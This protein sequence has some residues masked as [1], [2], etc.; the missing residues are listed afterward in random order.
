MKGGESRVLARRLLPYLGRYAWPHF[1]VALACMAIYSAT[2]GVV[3]YLVRSL[4]DD[5]L[6]A[7]DA[8]TLALLP[9]L[10]VAV[11][12]VRAAAGFGQ[13]YLGEYVGQHV[14]RDLR[15]DLDDKIQHLPVGYFDRVASGSVLSRVTT[16][17]LL[18]RQALTEGAAAVLR[19]AATVVIL[20]A[21]TFYLDFT[22]AV[23]T[24]VVF[25]AVVLPLQRLSRKM[26]RLSHRGLDSLGDLSALLQ[27]TL[28]GN[29]VV[30]AFG[31]QGYEK[32]R[33]AAENERLL[34]INMRAARIKAFTAPMTEM[35]AALAVAGVLAYG[36]TSVISGGR[37]PGGF[38]AF[39][40]ALVLLYEPFKKIVRTNNVVQTGLGAA[41][42]IFDILDAPAEGSAGEGGLDMKPFTREIRFENVGF[43]YD[44]R[45][46]LAGVDLTIRRGE[47]VALVG[48]SG[49]GKTTLA[50][51]VP[52]FY[53]V[54]SGR[55]T[56]DGIDVRD[57]SL[58][59]LRSQIAVVT[60]FTFLFND[61]V[62]NN[63][64]YGRADT[65]RSDI[66]AAAD[67]ANASAF[68]ERLPQGYDTV[69]GE[70]GVQLSGGERQRIAIARALVKDAPILILDEATS[71]LDAESERLVQEAIEALMR[72]RTVVVIAHRLSTVRG[73]DRIVV[74][75]GGRIS[76][77]GTHGELLESSPLYKRLNEAG[78]EGGGT[79]GAADG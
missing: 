58:A 71:A 23:V 15:A 26:R 25:P 69:V 28:V 16:D 60:Q 51:L 74:V 63:I 3:P 2:S 57:L 77:T 13:A 70:L 72:E 43:A 27:E 40:S 31:M 66:A 10:I 41:R 75:D 36:G 53:E 24:F 54:G 1:A 11:F 76:A 33:F 59:S 79:P 52:R 12:A 46:V 62:A 4:V 32:A 49:A 17:V 29:R 38:L 34:R 14:V 50:D 73:A 6:S 21:V 22:L 48:P 67:R 39:L 19:D 42:R 37:T 64:A 44:D 5:V 9:G 56:V 47:V 45:S 65:S 30:K 68:I 35:M 8:R 55:V 61:T 78:F 7:G 18:V 20:L